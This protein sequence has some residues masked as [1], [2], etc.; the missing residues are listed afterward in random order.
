MLALV[1][2]AINS[3]TCSII[4]ESS[5]ATLIITKDVSNVDMPS[6]LPSPMVIATPVAKSVGT[7]TVSSQSVS[8]GHPSISDKLDNYLKS[9]KELTSPCLVL[10]VDMV[11]AN[12][13]VLADSMPAARIFYAVK[14]NP[15]VEILERIAG[16]G[17]NFDTASMGEIDLCL[18]LGIAPNRLSFG[19]TIKKE[20][21][22]A[23]AYSKVVHYY[24]CCSVAPLCSYC[25]SFLTYVDGRVYNREC[26]CSRSMLYPSLKRSHV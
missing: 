21:D 2:G 5:N 25:I 10:D 19:N 20:R 23:V 14:A 12:Y 15:A 4:K 7:S 16:M 18:S 11:E 9:N 24:C 3:Q 6:P 1:M 22:I 8:S 26:A 13:R 17:S